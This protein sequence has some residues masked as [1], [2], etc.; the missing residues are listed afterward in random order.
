[1]SR[2]GSA[3]EG[4]QG[5]LTPNAD[6]SKITWFR[7]GGP[8]GTPVPA[9][10][11]G[12]ISRAFLKALPEDVPLTVVGIG[13]NLLV[14]DGGIPGVVVRLSAK[15][16]G[17]VE[18]VSETRIKAGAATPD[19]RLAAVCARSGHRRLSLLPRHSRRHRRR[20]QDECRGQR[21]RD[22]RAR[23]RGSGHRSRKATSTS[24]RMP[25]WA[26]PTAIQ[27]PRTT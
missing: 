21:R 10:R 8:A 16:F 18:R 20:A 14:R 15:G 27:L 13:S 12:R 9:G 25:T 6:M 22:A 5:R 4:L 3:L 17:T 7:A 24:C 26:I 11:R 2:L 1:M 23:R 19:K